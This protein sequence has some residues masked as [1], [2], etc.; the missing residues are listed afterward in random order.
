MLKVQSAWL[1]VPRQGAG[2]KSGQE[3][4]EERVGV[5]EILDCGG[6]DVNFHTHPPLYRNFVT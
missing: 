3:V 2:S 4:W 1:V 5:K 6:S